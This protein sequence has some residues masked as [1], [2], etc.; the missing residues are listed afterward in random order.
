M[1]KLISIMLSIVMLLCVFTSS[2]PS[3]ALTYDDF[4]YEI[5]DE[6]IVITGYSGTDVQVTVPA[7]FDGKSVVKIG[8]GAFKN[9]EIITSVTVSTGVEDIGASAFE[10]C[11][12]LA[13]IS[14]PTTITHVGE[15]AIYN[16]A[17]YNDESNWK[18]KRPTNDGNVNIGGSGVQDTIP[19]EDVMAPVLQYLYLGTVLIECELSGK[20][21]IKKGTTVIADYAFAGS[22]SAKT[23]EFPDSLVSI[24]DYA[25]LDCLSLETLE[26]SEDIDFNVTSIYNTGFYNNSKNWENGAFYMGTRL[27]ESKN[28]E[29]VVKDGTTHI[30]DSALDVERVVIPASVTS[31]HP[32]AFTSTEDVIIFCYANTSAQ[33]FATENNIKFI[34][35]ENLTKGDVNFNGELDNEDY[36]ILCNITTL[37]LIPSFT[38]SLAGDMNEDGT[39]D[40]LDVIILD[41]FI[42]DIGP[43]T[44]KGDTDG[45][46]KVNED[47]YTLL[48][49][50]VTL[51]TEITDVYMFDRCDLNYDGA[52]DSFDALYLDLA[53]NG[54]TAIM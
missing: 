53:L 31:I 7:E 22:E 11:T 23:I 27:V 44:I 10:N 25:F 35:L 12:S 33:T 17:Y 41:L 16:T 47:D 42:N 21:N 5:L 45:N 38:I 15:K 19:W 29:T 39:I 54:L 3:F 4:T 52:V 51:N 49:E 8:D 26:I 13:T 36:K 32:N 1:K 30:L 46:G 48:V 24:G 50:I 28:A 37:Q 9:N 34:N 18:L 40:G 14:L 6:K 20:Y 2:L 43:S